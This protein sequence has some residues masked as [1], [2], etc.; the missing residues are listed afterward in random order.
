MVWEN[1][2]LVEKYLLDNL[3]AID[4]TNHLL[5]SVWFDIVRDKNFEY[6]INDEF[7]LK[8]INKFINIQLKKI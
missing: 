8:I 2:L 6:F 3:I 7:K 4:Y 1:A 5:F